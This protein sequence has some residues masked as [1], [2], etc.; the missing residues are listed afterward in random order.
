MHVG[1]L[2]AGIAAWVGV[3]ALAVGMAIWDEPVWGFFPILAAVLVAWA[4]GEYVTN[5]NWKDEGN[6]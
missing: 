5:V 3:G 4:V 6:A 2:L 1:L